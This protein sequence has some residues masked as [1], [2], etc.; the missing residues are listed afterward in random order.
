MTW[1]T[2]VVIGVA[3]VGA[4]FAGISRSGI[5]MVAGLAKGLDHEEA[6]RFSFMLATPIILAAGVYK[7]PDLM[8][9]LGNGI[10]G[11]VIVG[12]LAARARGLRVGAVPGALLPQQQPRT[13][14]DLLPR[15]RHRVDDPLRV[16]TAWATRTARL[17]DPGRC[18]PARIA[19]QRSLG[20]PRCR[21]AGRAVRHAT[22]PAP[23]RNARRV[24]PETVSVNT[25]LVVPV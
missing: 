10:R 6:A 16:G 23:S 7:L 8:G 13:V 19:T 15:L 17:T 4:L 5:T 21:S 25:P 20:S 2:A 24:R 11:Q 14:R 9:N 1:R 18:T 12:S 3:Q 22:G